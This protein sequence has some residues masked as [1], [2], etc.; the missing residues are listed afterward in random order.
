[1]L[2][3]VPVIPYDLPDPDNHSFFFI[4][5]RVR[6]EDEAKLHRHDAWEIHCVVR[7]S[8][9]FTAGDAERAFEPGDV[10]L[11]PPSLP[12][13]WDYVPGP[14]TVRYRMAAFSPSFLESV[15]ATFPEVRNVLAGATLPEEASFF[16]TET[17]ARIQRTMAALSEKGDFG[18]LLGLLELLP[19]LFLSADRTAAWKCRP[20]CGA[21]KRP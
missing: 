14:G 5:Q 1:M 16:G 10:A 9:R 20:A 11:I 17:A 8:G 6:P 7:G 4:D 18:R 15:S 13:Q 12:H 21:L 2:L 3:S 19:T